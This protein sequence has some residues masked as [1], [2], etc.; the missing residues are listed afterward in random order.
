MEQRGKD[1][2]YTDLLRIGTVEAMKHTA[3][4]DVLRSA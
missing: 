4:L 3:A 1:V 2:T